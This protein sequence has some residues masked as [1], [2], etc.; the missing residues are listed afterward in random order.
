MSVQ[1][2]DT[3]ALL[4][5]AMNTFKTLGPYQL[6]TVPWVLKPPTFDNEHREDEI[7]NGDRVECP[8]RHGDMMNYQV[9]R[10]VDAAQITHEEQIE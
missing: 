5:Y 4:A 10:V 7:V 9:Q 6:T 3:Q 8:I 2:F 1:E